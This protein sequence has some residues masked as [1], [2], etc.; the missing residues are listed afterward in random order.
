MKSKFKI[1]VAAIAVL[2]STIMITSFVIAQNDSIRIVGLDGLVDVKKAGSSDWVSA[3]IGMDLTT[4]DSVRSTIGSYADLQFKDGGVIRVDEESNML[5]E[6]L[7]TDT[8]EVSFMFFMKKP[9]KSQKTKLKMLKGGIM[10]SLKTQP[11]S[12]STFHVETPKGIAGVRGTNWEVAEGMLVCMQGT[13]YWF[14]K[15]PNASQDFVQNIANNLKKWFKDKFGGS[16]TSTFPD[17]VPEGFVATIGSDGTFLGFTTAS[18]GMVA[19]M[20]DFGQKYRG[21]TTLSSNPQKALEGIKDST[22]QTVSQQES[23]DYFIGETI[24]DNGM[25]HT[26]GGP[27]STGS[28]SSTSGVVRGDA[29][30]DPIDQEEEANPSHIP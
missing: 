24:A 29:T 6:D 21:V 22:T 23:D 1:A 26:Q 16:D 4:G 13:V 10:A 11:T 17:S 5:I 15:D 14:P 27:G 20:S 9:V 28:I 2:I 8:K 25:G 7:S 18:D 3:Q 30:S 12:Q 19:I